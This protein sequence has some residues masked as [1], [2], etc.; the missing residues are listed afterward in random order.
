MFLSPPLLLVSCCCI[1]KAIIYCVVVSSSNS[2]YFHRRWTASSLL[3]FHYQ[4]GMSLKAYTEV[5]QEFLLNSIN[6][7]GWVGNKQVRGTHPGQIL[8]NVDS[9]FGL[10]IVLLKIL[11]LFICIVCNGDRGQLAETVLSF[12]HRDLEIEFRSSGLAE[13]GS[14][15]WAILSNP[16]DKFFKHLMSA[17]L[18]MFLFL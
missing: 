3:S 7:I 1:W 6:F 14:T 13:S 16:I 8:D 12:Y 17:F 15:H 2:F 4:L 11:H 9:V 5:L 18:L 10:M